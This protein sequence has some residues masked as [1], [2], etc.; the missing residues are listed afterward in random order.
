[1]NNAESTVPVDAGAN[2]VLVVDD[3][4]SQRMML[5]RLLRKGNYES[6][7]AMSTEEARAQLDD[8]EFG[9]VIAD[10]HMFREDGIELVRHVADKH[11]NTYSVVVSGFV[12]ETDSARIRRA[13]AF[14]LMA[15]PV[16]RVAFLEMVERAFVDRSLKLAERGGR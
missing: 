1:M 11:P 6:A 10:L 16:A 2:R 3:D 8:S 5:V 4:L 12:S 9:L 15:K 14:E 13:G 7:L